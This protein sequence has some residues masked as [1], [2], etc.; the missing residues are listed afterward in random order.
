MILVHRSLRGR[1][2]W[3]TAV[4]SAAVVVVSLG[5]IFFVMRGV[6]SHAVR[7]ALYDQFGVVAGSVRDGIDTPLPDDE[8]QE[9]TWLFDADG[10][11][12]RQPAAGERVQRFA[13]SLAHTATTTQRRFG[14]RAFLA[15]P[16][17]AADGTFRG[18]AVVTESLA[19]YRAINRITLITFVVVGLIVTV[20]ATAIA[21]WAV[22]R[23]FV[24]VQRMADTA[25]EWSEHQM[26]SRFAPGGADVEVAHLSATLNSLLD[27][28]AGAIRAEQRLTAELA[29][30]LRTPLTSIRAEAELALMDAP[31]PSV[32]LRMER[33]VERVDGMSATIATLLDVARRATRDLDES[34]AA[35]VVDAVL[36]A[37][38]QRAGVHIDVRVPSDL[39]VSAPTQ[40]AVRALAPLVENAL[41]HARSSVTVAVTETD[42]VRFEISDDGPGVDSEDIAAASRHGLG[43]ALSRRLARTLGGDVELTSRRDPT[44]FVLVLPSP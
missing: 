3:T 24:P 18:V 9:T 44:T 39:A 11:V 27:R 7:D 2:V 43:L 13:A 5:T 4:L 42:R 12:V 21:A 20:G 40:I 17:R 8:L 6:Q 23:T 35:E 25:R 38:S 1:I 16:V 41:H 19:T 15:G 32:S 30:E 22:R 36:A 29:H 10:A 37:G 28:V 31:N 34:A 33:I 26:Q 14:D